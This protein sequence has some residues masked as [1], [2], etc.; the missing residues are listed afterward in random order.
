MPFLI[1]F[2][3]FRPPV[4][5]IVAKVTSITQ[6]AG[7]LGKIL[8]LRLFIY[9]GHIKREVFAKFVNDPKIQLFSH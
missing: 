2:V 4:P 3:I 6:L 9:S 1:I 5:L 7:I 8:E